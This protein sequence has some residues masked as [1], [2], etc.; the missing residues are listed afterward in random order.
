MNDSTTQFWKDETIKYGRNQARELRFR[1]WDKQRQIFL[2]KVPTL[3][4]TIGHLNVSG[5]I[6][7]QFTGLKDKNGKDIYEGDILQAYTGILG[8]TK[9]GSPKE[10]KWYPEGAGW[11]VG[12][13]DKDT[14]FNGLG[15]YANHFEIIGN[16]YENKIN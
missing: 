14:Y 7:S 1:C 16:I 6:F 3:N 12:T 15:I 8:K 10:V 5:Y 4:L 11:R 2:E 9:D 13:D